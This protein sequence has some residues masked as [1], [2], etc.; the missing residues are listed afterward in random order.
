MILHATQVMP[1][2]TDVINALIAVDLPPPCV[3]LYKNLSI[4]VSLRKIFSLSP[5]SWMALMINQ[6][7]SLQSTLKFMTLSNE[8]ISLRLEIDKDTFWKLTKIAADDQQHVEEWLEGYLPETA[9]VIER[10]KAGYTN[11]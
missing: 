5:L 7:P 3:L 9:D 1:T 10:T 11:K 2:G 6:Q 8:K 4:L